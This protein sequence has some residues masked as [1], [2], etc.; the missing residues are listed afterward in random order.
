MRLKVIE[1]PVVAKLIAR[2]R[3][4]G[5]Q[6][7]LLEDGERILSRNSIAGATLDIPIEGTCRPSKTCVK[8]CYAASSRQAMPQMLAHQYRVQHTME[9]DPVAF[10]ERVMSEYDKLGLTYLR[11]NGVGDLSEAAVQTINWIG[12]NRPDAVLWVVTRKPELASKIEHFP[13]V[14]VHFSLDSM[15]L[16]RRDQF[17]ASNPRSDNYFFSYQCERD[18]IPPATVKASVV[19]HRRYKLA[20]GSDPAN[21]ALC[22]LNLLTDWTGACSNCRRCFNGKAVQSREMPAGL[23]TQGTPGFTQMDELL[24][25]G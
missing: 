22:P 20:K 6:T 11:W 1:K 14:Y 12:H 18:E 19:F 23:T 10:A 2:S 4:I 5:Q 7:G 24:Q 9:A 15:S 17:L 3:P 16:D 25:E 21:P 8:D 13:N